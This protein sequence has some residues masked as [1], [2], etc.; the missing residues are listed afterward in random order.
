MELGF[1]LAIMVLTCN[2][3]LN[4]RWHGFYRLQTPLLGSH[5]YKATTTDAAERP[6]GTA[7]T[8]SLVVLFQAAQRRGH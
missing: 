3:L 4:F 6:K 7:F 5:F 2:K 8:F 1:C